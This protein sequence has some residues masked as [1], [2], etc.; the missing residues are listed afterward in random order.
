MP[1]LL[2]KIFERANSYY[3]DSAPELKEERATLLEDWLNMETNFGNLGDVSVVQSKLPKK[4]KKR[5][6]IT[7]ED[8]STEYEEY[9]DYLYPEESQTTNL[10]ILEAA[11]KWKKQ[12]LAASEEDYD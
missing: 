3:K 7:R 5:K 8:G 11:Y 6:P 4:L 12:K 2:W 10:K 1:E 9:I